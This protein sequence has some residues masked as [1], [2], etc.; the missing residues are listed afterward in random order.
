MLRHVL[1]I[2]GAALMLGATTPALASERPGPADPLVVTENFLLARNARDPMAATALCSPLLAIR[3]GQSQWIA[4]QAAGRDWLRS[5][6]DTYTIDMLVHPRAEGDHVVW[7][8]RLAPRSLPF[9]Q[10]LQQS[11]Q[12]QVEVTVQDGKIVSYTAPYP[13]LT[14]Q[15]PQAASQPLGGTAPLN[16]PAV[17]PAVAFTSWALVLGG[18]VLLAVISRSVLRRPGTRKPY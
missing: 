7:V 6:T 10:A 5:L 13:G 1:M 16:E 2:F 15:P 17:P 9:P 18:I 3:D 14:P 8:E 12:V 4:D 11:I